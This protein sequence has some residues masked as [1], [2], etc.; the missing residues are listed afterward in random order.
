[1]IIVS[2]NACCENEEQAAQV[3]EVLSRVLTG[4]ALDG[5]MI[6]LNMQRIADD[7]NTPAVGSEEREGP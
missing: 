7:D 6:S 1:M 5:I 3:A 4:V 2:L